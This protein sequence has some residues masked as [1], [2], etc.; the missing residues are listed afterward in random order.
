[1]N[2]YSLTP[3][4]WD[5]IWDAAHGEWAYANIK[6]EQGWISSFFDL[7]LLYTEVLNI[8]MTKQY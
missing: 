8:Q 2:C 4:S 5:A 7:K 3:Q 6:G 1:M